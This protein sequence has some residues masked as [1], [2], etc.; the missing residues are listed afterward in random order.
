MTHAYSANLRRGMDVTLCPLRRLGDPE[1]SAAH[2]HGRQHFVLGAR[3]RDS[4][5]PPVSGGVTLGDR[6]LIGARAVILEGLSVGEG[7]VIGAVA[8][9]TR[10][11][12]AFT[13]AKG[14]PAR[15][16]PDGA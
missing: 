2:G 13:V 12:P 8:V 4:H 11:V 5:V 3:S 16:S 6:D 14:I 10:D 9:V 7:A 1:A 15:F